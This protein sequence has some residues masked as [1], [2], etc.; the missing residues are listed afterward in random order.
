MELGY[1]LA[2]RGLIFE[3]N[4]DAI[5]YHYAER[6]FKSWM[7]TPYVYGRSDVVFSRDK[8]H[9]W[10]LTQLL[11]E[12]RGRHPIVQMLVRTCLCR[13]RCSS[14]ASSALRLVARIGGSLGWERALLGAYSGIFN[15]RYLQGIADEL[16]GRR[17]FFSRLSSL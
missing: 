16:G 14:F 1:R 10:L 5:G 17:D 8:G 11:R 2:E 12:F 7:T 3:Y 6:S 15:L 13:Q 9:A 4:P